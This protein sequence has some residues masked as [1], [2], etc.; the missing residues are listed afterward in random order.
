MGVEEEEDLKAESWGL[1]KD[2]GNWREYSQQLPQSLFS[3][4]RA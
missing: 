4:V 1:L 3:T 2:S